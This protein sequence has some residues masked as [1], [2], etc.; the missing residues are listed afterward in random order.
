MV[1]S[2]NHR[3][4]S[5]TTQPAN[6]SA[7]H[8]NSQAI[9][10]CAPFLDT[11]ALWPHYVFLWLDSWLHLGPGNGFHHVAKACYTGW[12]LDPISIPGS[13]WEAILGMGAFLPTLI[14]KISLEDRILGSIRGFAKKGQGAS[15][16]WHPES[17]RSS[18]AADCANGSQLGP[19]G[20][21]MRHEIGS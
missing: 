16:F 11:H 7:Q 17:S 18:P 8:W 9:F 3:E 12:R 6:N 21:T 13:D 1:R 20:A 14:Q 10:G 5:L 19:V 15:S 4:W 2:Q